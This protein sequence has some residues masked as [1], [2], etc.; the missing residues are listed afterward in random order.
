MHG[1]E[2]ERAIRDDLLEAG[3]TQHCKG[4]P[5]IQHASCW[6]TIEQDDE[7]T[8]EKEDMEPPTSNI[9]DA[10]HQYTQPPRIGNNV[11][12]K[13]VTCAEMFTV[14]ARE[15][16]TGAKIAP[17]SRHHSSGVIPR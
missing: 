17:S 10:T 11:T 13:E 5:E 9:R 14:Q 6:L 4:E 1:L 12:S 2:F 8:E 7:I 15:S 3:K 16:L